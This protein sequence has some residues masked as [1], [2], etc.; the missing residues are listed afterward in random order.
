MMDVQSLIQFY[1][2]NMGAKVKKRNDM[3]LVRIMIRDSII[4]KIDSQNAI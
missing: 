4:A 2:V 3:K 1:G